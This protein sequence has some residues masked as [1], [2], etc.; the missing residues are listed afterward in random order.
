MEAQVAV[1]MCSDG[2]EWESGHSAVLH[3][4]LA[5]LLGSAVPM[6]LDVQR[7]APP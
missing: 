4:H 2:E 7:H 6:S 5:T 3:A 1:H